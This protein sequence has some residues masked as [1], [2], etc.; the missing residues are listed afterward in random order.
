MTDALT[1]EECDQICFVFLLLKSKFYLH[2]GELGERHSMLCVLFGD[3]TGITRSHQ[4]LQLSQA[5][6][7][8][9]PQIE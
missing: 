4:R 5:R 2:V 7:D 9:R 1:V 6:K 8:L 3:H